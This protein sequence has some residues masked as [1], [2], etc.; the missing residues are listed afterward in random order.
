M[1]ELCKRERDKHNPCK[2]AQQLLLDVI[3][4]DESLS[5]DQSGLNAEGISIYRRNLLA[6]AQRALSISFPTVFELV[7]SDISTRL[8]YQFLRIAPPSQGDWT[9]WGENFPHFLE[10]TG[11]SD[12]YP[13]IP[14][15]AMLDWYVHCA[16]HGSD[17]TLVQT[18]LR[19]L[20]D[21]EP[22]QIFIEFNQNVK[23]FKTEYPL[24][25]IFQAHHHNDEDLREVA[26]NDAKILL[27][28]GPKEQVV[29]VYRPEFQPQVTKLTASEGTFMLCLLSGK[30]LE[31]SLDTVKN[32]NDFSFEKWLITA[33]ERNI[34]YY[35]KER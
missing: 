26:M 11:L 4:N 19:Y 5:L 31:Q 6:N 24:A 34:I 20:S 3:W 12:S 7:D 10:T 35:F 21:S 23:V 28:A 13:Y 14:G 17:Q 15:C 33:I 22:A 32:D 25:D 29:M 8:V 1:S 2:N 18:S 30:S 16:L 27:S 9:Q